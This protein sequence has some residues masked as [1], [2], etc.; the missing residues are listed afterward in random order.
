M[1]KRKPITHTRSIHET[2]HLSQMRAE[3]TR[4]ALLGLTIKHQNISKT[5]F[6]VRTDTL[7]HRL[8]T[9][10]PIIEDAKTR[11]RKKKK[12]EGQKRDLLRRGYGTQSGDNAKV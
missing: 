8:T 9:G 12:V 6:F 2:N 1:Q 4:C 7:K 11:E 3:E 10:I 5:S